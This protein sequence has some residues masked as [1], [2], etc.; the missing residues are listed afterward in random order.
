MKS[1]KEVLE[2]SLQ[3]NF[4]RFLG[5]KLT[6]QLISK[7]PVDFANLGSQIQLG[8]KV[9]KRKEHNFSTDSCNFDKFSTVQFILDL[10]MQH[11]V[12][13]RPFLV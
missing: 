12:I 2:F 11:F 6:F 8:F 4:W 13:S 9:K 10:G 1:G 7:L 3:L 5:L